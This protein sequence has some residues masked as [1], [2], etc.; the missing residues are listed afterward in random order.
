M[1]ASYLHVVNPV[2]YL[3]TLAQRVTNRFERSLFNAQCNIQTSK[4]TSFSK[5][6]VFTVFLEWSCRIEHR[7]FFLPKRKEETPTFRLRPTDVW[8]ILK[9]DTGICIV[10]LSMLQYRNLFSRLARDAA[11]MIARRVNYFFF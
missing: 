8:I 5:A 3:K 9:Y 6:A 2:V 1:R 10:R 11:N 4:S 7:D